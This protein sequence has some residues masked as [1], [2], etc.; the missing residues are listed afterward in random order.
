MRYFPFG[1]L[2]VLLVT[3]LTIT[4]LGP[5]YFGFA[6][7]P[8]PAPEPADYSNVQQLGTI[9]YTNYAYPFEIAGVLLLAAIIAA[10]TLTHRRG[11]LRRKIAKS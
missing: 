5:N 10:I 2:V 4:A 1:L 3:G 6:Q 9:L 11:P 7:M 8:L